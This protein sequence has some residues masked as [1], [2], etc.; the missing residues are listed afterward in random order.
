MSN[1]LLFIG[2]N[3]YAGSG[4]DTVAKMLKTILSYPWDNLE[5]C[6]SYYKQRYTNPT[7]SATFNINNENET[8]PVMC[9]AYADQ[10]K[11]IC[12]NMFG[13]PLER[14]YMNKSNAWVCINDRFQYTEIQPEE[15]NII[16]ADDYYNS[17]SSYINS[18]NKYW[19]SLREILV[20]VGTY[21]LQQD[22]NRQIFV[23]IV[24]NKINNIANINHKL[25]YV[26]VTDNRFVHEL[27]YIKENS[28][29][30]MT[31][32]RDS[33]IQLDN[34]AEHD[35]DD[36]N[37]YDY[38]IEN[39]DGY[40]E[41]FEQVWNIV[42]DDVE[43]RNEIIELQTRDDVEN[44]L[45]LIDKTDIESVYKLCTPLKIQQS[46]HSD[47][48]ITMIDPC[49]GPILCVGEIIKGSKGD[50][51]PYGLMISNIKFDNEQFYIYV[52]NRY[53]DNVPQIY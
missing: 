16:T 22:V 30:L 9:I 8:M 24:R 40:D 19:M 46:Y 44:Y 18:N 5:S 36:E 33:V 2:L 21:V 7:I 32:T 53:W 6:K 37:C 20:Y 10:L 14:F 27:D 17:I 51:N 1:K 28:G 41:L 47:G 45:R 25:K 23:N 26:I 4:K 12:S 49:G 38:I 42:H 34:I 35:L 11:E 29:I 43:F 52:D 13:I 31:I 50:N 15:D 48:E 3:G 39:N